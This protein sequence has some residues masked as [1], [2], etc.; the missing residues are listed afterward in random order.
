MTG[1]IMSN[2]E[3]HD[4]PR[5]G[6]ST[7]K[8][9]L[10]HPGRMSAPS[11]IGK[12]IADEG[13]RLHCA[14][15]EP[16]QMHLRYVVA[17]DPEDHPNALRTLDDLKGALRAAGVKGYSAKKRDALADMVRESV[18]GAVLWA[19][20]LS[21]HGRGAEGKTFVSSDEWAEMERARDAAMSHPV[22]KDAG[23]FS[24]GVAE[25][26]FFA[27]VTYQ[28]PGIFGRR[29]PLKCR[30]D[31]LQDRRVTDLKTWKGG[32]SLDAFYRQAN[33]LHYDLSAALYLDVLREHGHKSDR[34]TWVVLDKSTL[35]TGGRVL[36]HVATLSPAFI[37]QGREKLSVALD[38]INAW[39][40]SPEVYDRQFMVE[41]MA[42]P[43]AW[44]WR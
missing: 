27:D 12:K 7:V 17:P 25:R 36:I 14:I 20:I 9:A 29:W 43:P 4:D 39:E 35:R 15:L 1:S 8:R 23:I 41:H 13:T 10:T 26:S 37:E 31:W 11:G 44:G 34:F 28:D 33:A 19:D 22:I 42:E 30:P 3:Y 2:A 6:S 32:A 16:D 5:L 38:R 21:D 40:A 18:P 24:E